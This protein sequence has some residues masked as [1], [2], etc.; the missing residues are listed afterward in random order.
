MGIYVL[1]SSEMAGAKISKKCQKIRG[2][3]FIFDQIN[4]PTPTQ[5]MEYLDAHVL[6]HVVWD[7]NTDA[8]EHVT[9]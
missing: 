4:L 7:Y 3:N 9:Y 2:H 8:G 6:L 1:Y 5:L